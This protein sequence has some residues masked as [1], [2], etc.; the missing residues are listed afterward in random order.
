MLEHRSG[1]DFAQLQAMQSVSLDQSFEGGREHRLVAGGGIGTIGT[2]E[3]NSI[4]A[5]DR[6]PAQ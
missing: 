2:G 1:G 6:D 5:N 3:G 4:A